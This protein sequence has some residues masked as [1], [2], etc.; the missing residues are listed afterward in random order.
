MCVSG[1]MFTLGSKGFGSQQMFK[2][3][4]N[5]IKKNNVNKHTVFWLK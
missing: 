1:E 3:N 5:A 4:I 2:Q